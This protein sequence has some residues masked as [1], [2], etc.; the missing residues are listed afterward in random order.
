MF[1]FLPSYLV[2]IDCWKKSAIRSSWSKQSDYHLLFI[3]SL[4]Q[5]GLMER[6]RIP[7]TFASSTDK[8][9][10]EYL[11]S[12]EVRRKHCIGNQVLSQCSLHS[13]NSLCFIA[14]RSI[15]FKWCYANLK[16]L[17][18]T[19]NNKSYYSNDGKIRHQ[20]SHTLQHCHD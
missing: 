13:C 20:L 9:N 12:Q 14:L 6:Q 4:L 8:I 7:R 3:G 10:C 18:Y 19:G 15:D 5:V 11:V 2:S 1:F 17:Y 16:K